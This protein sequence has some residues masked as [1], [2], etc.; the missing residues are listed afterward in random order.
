MEEKKHGGVRIGAGRPKGTGKGTK[1]I[2]FQISCQLE[3]LAFIEKQ[4][5]EKGLTKS[6]YMLSLLPNK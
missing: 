2:V 4:A 1:R 6:A 5:N 3:E